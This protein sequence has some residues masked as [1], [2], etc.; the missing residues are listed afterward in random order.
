M[1]ANLLPEKEDTGEGM[2]TF[3]RG[4]CTQLQWAVLIR[5]VYF[6]DYCTWMAWATAPLGFA[7]LAVRI[8]LHCTGKFLPTQVPELQLWMTGS[9]APH[10]LPASSTAE[11]WRNIEGLNR[12]LCTACSQRGSPW[13]DRPQ[14][15]A[16]GMES[17]GDPSR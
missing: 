12:P 5:G 6:I 11:T 15:P 7:D 10:G 16:P 9:H 1:F 17:L 4:G 8:D 14:D 2:A 3:P 13:P